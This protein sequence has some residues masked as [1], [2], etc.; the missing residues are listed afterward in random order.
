LIGATVRPVWLSDTGCL[1]GRCN[2]AP[3]WQVEFTAHSAAAHADRMPHVT[4]V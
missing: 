2:A 4:L 3:Q 1:S